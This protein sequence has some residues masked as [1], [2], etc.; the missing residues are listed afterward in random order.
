M[1]CDCSWFSP[2]IPAPQNISHLQTARILNRPMHSMGSTWAWL[3]ATVSFAL[4]WTAT[5]NTFATKP[6]NNAA[7]LWKSSLQNLWWKKLWWLVLSS[8]LCFD[9]CQFSV[10]SLACPCTA[11][12]RGPILADSK[13]PTQWGEQVT[14]TWRHG[15]ETQRHNTDQTQTSR[16][17]PH[18]VLRPIPDPG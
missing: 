11:H 12:F 13:P 8:S 1:V 7:S 16:S 3:L 4:G 5:M 18:G 17:E 9:F 10:C 6:G 15:T 14:A 2:F